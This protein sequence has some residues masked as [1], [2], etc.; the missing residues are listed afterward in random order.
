MSADI[1][2]PHSDSLG[3]TSTTVAPGAATGTSAATATSTSS[4]SSGADTLP[5]PV[6]PAEAI[7]AAP[8]KALD[9]IVGEPTILDKAQAL[10]KPY[11]DKV[12]PYA[13][14]VQEAAKP[15]TDKAAAKTKEIIDK[16]EGNSPS[17]SPV[18]TSANTVERSTDSASATTSEVGEKAKGIFE[19]GLSAVQST[20]TQ[21]TH[22]ID[23]KTASPTHPGFITQ[24]TN[25]VHKGVEKVEKAFNEATD[26]PATTAPAGTT[27]TGAAPTIPTTTNTLPHP[28]L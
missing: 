8:A 18:P 10:A 26:G 1:P 17:T 6:T 25:A 19:Q 21:I 7:P 14:K 22:T 24:V 9:P 12:E 13:H 16:I 23:E 11:L 3:A 27:G 4:A 28:P 5:K 15:Y 20:F 2:A